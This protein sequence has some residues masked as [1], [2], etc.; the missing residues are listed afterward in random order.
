MCSPPRWILAAALVFGGMAY[1]YAADDDRAC[2]EGAEH[3]V[4]IGRQA[5]ANP[6]SRPE[7]TAKRRKLVEGW[8]A[9]LRRGEDPCTVYADIHRAATS[10]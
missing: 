9:R 3:M 2:R 6:D 1:S 8:D 7:R 4:E 10:F 5:L